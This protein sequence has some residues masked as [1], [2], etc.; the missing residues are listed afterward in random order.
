MP[1]I[2]PM[3]IMIVGVIVVLIF[4]PRRLPELGKSLGGGMREFK[5]SI[6]AHHDKADAEAEQPVVTL[7]APR[8]A[9]AE[10]AKSADSPSPPAA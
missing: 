4:G 6:T 3:E 10:T 9:A 7:E 1:N 8:V 5:N 2:G